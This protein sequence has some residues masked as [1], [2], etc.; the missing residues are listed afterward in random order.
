MN[1]VPWL[2]VML[3]SAVLVGPDGHVMF[4]LKVLYVGARAPI[5]L[6][7]TSTMPQKGSTR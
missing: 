4:V 6:P 2:T 3:V 7:T 5:A 1:A